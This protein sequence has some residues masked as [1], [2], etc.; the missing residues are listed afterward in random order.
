M[1]KI[2]LTF[3][4]LIAA[5]SFSSCKKN[6]APSYTVPTTY[7]FTNVNDTA[8]LEL[9]A[10]ADQIVAAINLGNTV[11]GATV[12]TQQL[13]D[14]FNNTNGYFN[15]SVYHLNASGISFANY[16]PASAK[17]DILNYFD[18]IG[19][20][21]QSTAVADSGVAGVSVS[22]V[23]SKKLLLS[24]NGI[25][26]AQVVKKT[27]MGILSYEIAN[28]Y[29]TDSISNSV[30][31]NT[32]VPGSG[33]AMEHHWDEAFGFFGAPVNFPATVTGIKYLASYSNQVDAGLHSNATIMNAYLKGRAAISNKDL[34]TKQ[35]QA[36]IIITTLDQ[37]DAAAIVQEMHE[38]ESDLNSGD[39]I[40]AYGTL[41]ES[42][43]FV[44][45]LKYNTSSTRIITDAQIAQLEALYDNVNPANPNLYAFVGVNAGLTTAQVEAK[46]TAIKIFIQGVY[47]FSDAE[48]L[49]L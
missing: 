37:L 49:L 35:A 10:M 36:N 44:R 11:G 15:D 13:T 27:I 43:G 22:T 16:C 45:N 7:N 30:D 38:T 1:K 17:T 29:L 4:I 28:V 14:M 9:I 3:C 24:P 18:S 12:S 47:G 20:Y 40:G 2:T 46:T 23:T 6:N 48:L 31:N 25:F 26:Y 8:Q 33:T 39:V 32:V 41:S 19:V 42:I 21:S 5:L 34:G